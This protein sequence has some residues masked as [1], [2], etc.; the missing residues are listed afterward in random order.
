[1]SK[2]QEFNTALKESM[3]N[4]DMTAVST[5]RL[6][7]AALKDRDVAARTSGQSEGVNETEILAMLQSMLK[8]RAESI[9]IYE[10]SDRQ[11]LAD[12]EH[13]E[14]KVIKKFLPEPLEGAELEKVIDDLIASTGAQSIKDMGKIMGALKTDYAGRVDMSATGALVRS[15]LSA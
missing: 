4:K 1:V 8:Q 10:K 15:K 14:V 13:A 6:I 7:L 3:K 2:R 12:R 9:C 5:I 11:D